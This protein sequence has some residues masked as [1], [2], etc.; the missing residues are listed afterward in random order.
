MLNMEEMPKW[1]GVLLIGISFISV[2]VGG[3]AVIELWIKR[4]KNL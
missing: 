3:L 4:D 2:L 1:L